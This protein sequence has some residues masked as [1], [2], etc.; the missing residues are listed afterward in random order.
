ME[1]IKD[2]ITPLVLKVSNGEREALPLY[3]EIV[4]AMKYLD[5]QKKFLFSQAYEEARYF[6]DEWALSERKTFSYKGIEEWVEKKKELKAV[7]DKYKAIFAIADKEMF[8]SDSEGE[9]QQLPEVSYSKILK[10]K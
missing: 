3:E 6:P 5:T 8:V 1:D 9:V 10:K 2:I 4:A 7:E